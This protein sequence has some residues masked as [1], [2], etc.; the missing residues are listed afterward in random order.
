MSCASFSNMVLCMRTI[1]PVSIFL[2]VNVCVCVYCG[3]QRGC[4]ASTATDTRRSTAGPCCTCVPGIS[5]PTATSRLPCRLYRRSS[6]PT[7]W[8]RCWPP[9]PDTPLRCG[10]SA[11]G[12][13][14][15]RSVWDAYVDRLC[16]VCVA[17]LLSTRTLWGLY[18]WSSVC[19]LYVVCAC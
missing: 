17:I 1:T 7:L 18:K 15:V 19:A 5:C 16:V 10:V 3:L 9:I 6:R 11:R 2:C 14:C 4:V 8:P 12:C 13:L